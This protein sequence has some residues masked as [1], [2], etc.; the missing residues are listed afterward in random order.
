MGLY[1]RLKRRQRR[2]WAYNTCSYPL[3]LFL[4]DVVGVSIKPLF[5]VLV[6]WFAYQ[7]LGRFASSASGGSKVASSETLQAVAIIPPVLNREQYSAQT[8]STP[9]VRDSL[10]TTDVM[11]GQETEHV[12]FVENSPVTASTQQL[13]DAE[14]EDVEN[15]SSNRQIVRSF[16]GRVPAQVPA[17]ERS[18]THT[19]LRLGARWIQVQEPD[20]YTVQFGTYS[21]IDGLENFRSLFPS[22]LTPVLF[23][24]GKVSTLKAEY[25][26]LHGAYRTAEAAEKIV[27]QM[28][29]ELREKTPRIRRISELQD[30]AIN[31]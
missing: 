17:E 31:P 22:Q 18:A 23:E 29:V 5:L 26:I 7:S 13:P 4:I 6:A 2:Y 20:L 10:G 16:P 12:A 11:R 21:S 3:I 27:G 14:S 24:F 19:E 30:V 25:G 9:T 1:S 28:P 15:A 8:D